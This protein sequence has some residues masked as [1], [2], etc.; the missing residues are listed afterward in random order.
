MLVLL[1]STFFCKARKLVLSALED[2]K[3]QTR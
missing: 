3:F 2:A 1:L